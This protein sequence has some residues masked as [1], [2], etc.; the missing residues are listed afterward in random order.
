LISGIVVSGFGLASVYVAPLTESLLKQYGIN[1]TFLILGVAFLLAI[2]LISQ[3]IKNP[4]EGYV[5]SEL[6]SK[7]SSLEEKP[8]QR[9]YDWHEMIKTSS[10]YLLWL[11]YAFA[12]FAG[13][14]IIG[15]MAKIAAAQLPGVNLGFLLVAILA[16]G[17]SLGRIVAGIISDKIGRTRAM[18]VV[19]LFQAL[20][21]GVLAISTTAVL[22]VIAAFLIGF[23]YGANLSLFP[24]TTSDYFGTKNLGVNYGLVFTA[25]GVGGVFGAQVAGKIVDTT[26]SYNWAYAVAATL[27]ILAAALTFVAKPPREG[28]A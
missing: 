28:K 14:M 12:S 19:F 15:H 8:A 3:L 17:N 21:M 11:M 10:F 20:M 6:S 22:L 16:I 1:Q 2:V 27:C 5:V 26:G 4:P 13:L 9:E 18:L 23:N 7:E 24:S 25:W